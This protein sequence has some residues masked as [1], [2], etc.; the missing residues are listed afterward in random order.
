MALCDLRGALASKR[1]VL[2]AEWSLSGG[3]RRVVHERGGGAGTIDDSTKRANAAA[4][5]LS[6]GSFEKALGSAEWMR[7]GE[8]RN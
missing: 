6:E 3:A 7:G 5:S 2:P 1:T 4:S 8:W